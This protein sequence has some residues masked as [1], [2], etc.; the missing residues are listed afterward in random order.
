MTVD[1]GFIWILLPIL[2][3]FFMSSKNADKMSHDEHASLGIHAAN[4]ASRYLTEEQKKKH[5][6]KKV[7]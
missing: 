6:E 3:F 7:D 5:L 2:L 1:N 4:K